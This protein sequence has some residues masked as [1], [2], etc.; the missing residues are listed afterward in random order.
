M[1]RCRWELI[2]PDEPAILAEPLLDAV[3]MEDLQGNGRLANPANTK[4]SNRNQP[5]RYIDNLL[6]QLITSKKDSGR[7]GRWFP[8]YP[9]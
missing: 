6:D 4:E 8:K 1:N 5:L 7:R 3:V 2:A 9:G